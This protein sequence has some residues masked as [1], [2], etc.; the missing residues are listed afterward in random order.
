MEQVVIH[1]GFGRPIY[2]RTFSGNADLQNN[3]L[4][5]MEHLD[6]LLNENSQRR[7]KKSHCSRALII[8]GAGN[9]VGTLRAFEKSEGYHYITILDTNQIHQRKF[10][11]LLPSERYTYGAASLTDCRIE[12]VDSKES[13]YIYESRAVHVRWDNGKE[14]CL[15]TSITKDIF[16]ASGVV[17]AYFDRWPLCEKQYAMMKAA[18]CFYQVVGYGK[19][20]LPD[21]NMI[22]RIEKLQTDLRRLRKDLNTPLSQIAKKDQELQSLFEKE[23]WLKESSKIK[24]GKRK[25]SRQNQKALESCQRDIR[26]TQRNIIKIQEPFK[27][28]FNFLRQ[29]NKEYARIQGKR[30]VYHVDVELDQLMTSFRLTLANLMAFL[31]KVILNETPIEMNTLIQSILF[32]SGRIEHL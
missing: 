21:E 15:V 26:K 6:E 3:A 2:F 29:K 32:L 25:Q 13:G 1:D 20:R 24:D 23:C 18:T 7:S 14:C 28:Q 8:D 17:K 31:A 19:K 12:L 30:E 27:K 9:A 4:R 22:E 16:D 10:K 11:H 5:S